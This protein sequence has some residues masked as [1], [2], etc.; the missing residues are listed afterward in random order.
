MD[1][2]ELEL[3]IDVDGIDVSVT[4][5]LADSEA[6]EELTVVADAEA[7]RETEAAEEEAARLVVAAADEDA[8]LDEA[9]RED[10]ELEEAGRDTEADDEATAAL[11]V[12]GAAELVVVVLAVS[13]PKIDIRYQPPH[14]CLESP[15]QAV[16]H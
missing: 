13:L 3:I 1:D 15:A 14:I 10:E 11:D 16:L 4:L 2:E 9:A 5:S 12:L 6:V 7:E 8:A